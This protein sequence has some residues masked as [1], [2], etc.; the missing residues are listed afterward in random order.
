MS[1]NWHSTIN[2]SYEQCNVQDSSLQNTTVGS[3]REA[4]FGQIQLPKIPSLRRKMPPKKRIAIVDKKGHYT[5]GYRGRQPLVF[6]KDLFITF[7]DMKWRWALLSFFALYFIV[8]FLFTLIWGFLCWVHGDFGDHGDR[9]H[10][11]CIKGIKS[12]T[13]LLFFS[14]ETQTS[15]GYGFVHPNTECTG[16]LIVLFFQ[17][18]FGLVLET[19]LL[20]YLISKLFRPSLRSKTIRF[21]KNAVICQEDGALCL[22][23]S[24]ID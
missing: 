2:G 12:F 9:D 21:S 14:I 13:S 4:L 8:F 7:V 24:K 15:I 17:I 20:T 16:S 6:F 3:L 11:P 23:V 19:F 22:Q 10:V 1:S 5:I 18:T